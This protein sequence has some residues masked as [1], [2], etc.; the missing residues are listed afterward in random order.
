MTT[1]AMST[2]QLSTYVDGE[3]APAEELEVRRHLETCEACAS[4]VETLLGLKEAV[5]ATAEVRPVPH[6]LRERLAGL[7]RGR[8]RSWRRW[9]AVATAAVVVLALAS[10]L[11]ARRA[12]QPAPAEGER[13]MEALVADHLHYLQVPDAIEIASHDPEHVAA[14]FGGKLPFPVRLPVL[15]G[16]DLL[17][18][19]LCSLWGHKVAL[20]FYESGGER[21]SLFV[22]DP[23]TF[24]LAGRR[25][26]CTEGL[27]DKRVCLVA[28]G[29]NV[30]AMVA[31]REQAAIFAPQLERLAAS[32]AQ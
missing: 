8:H 27:G 26:G 17:G 31:D 30:L 12:R 21:L 28:A 32:I 29:P 15:E 22:A 3:A 10:A 19:R 25:V 5:A 24:P 7:D 16:A 13:M 11:M 6:T 1:C 2:E 9:P 20:A 14:W 4:T 23:T 18:A